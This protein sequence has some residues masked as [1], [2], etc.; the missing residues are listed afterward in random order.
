MEKTLT[1]M[2]SDVN[3]DELVAGLPDFVQAK[4]HAKD[5]EQTGSTIDFLLSIT[6]FDSFKS[7]MLAAKMADEGTSASISLDADDGSQGLLNALADLH[8]EPKVQEHA[9]VLLKLSGAESGVEWKHVAQKKGSWL[10]EQGEVGGKTFMRSTGVIQLNV[11]HTIKAHCDLSDPRCCEWELNWGAVKLLSQGKS[12]DGKADFQTVSIDFKLP[13]VIKLI[14]TVPKS[15]IMRIDVE[16][17]VP[18]AGSA[19]AVFTT[20]DPAANAPKT[21]AMA[22][23]RV[24]TVEPNADGTARML[25]ISCSPPFMPTWALSLF[26]SKHIMTGMV[27]ATERY[28]QIKGI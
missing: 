6:E 16:H 15:M 10:L 4:A 7:L 3:M 11:E 28:K 18:K 1:E 8:I 21:G 25:N 26:L 2:A 13:G 12:S 17:D 14:P 19:M 22:M 24:V 23:V 20:W 27:Q 5:P 9:R